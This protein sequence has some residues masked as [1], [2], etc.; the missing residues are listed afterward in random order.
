VVACDKVRYDGLSPL[1]CLVEA[2]VCVSPAGAE[3]ARE[4]SVDFL[5]H[6]DIAFF[7]MPSSASLF[8]SKKREKKKKKKNCRAVHRCRVAVLVAAAYASGR[9]SLSS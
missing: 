1:R 9:P 6:F 2:S 5:F 4:H 3:E 7:L 8:R